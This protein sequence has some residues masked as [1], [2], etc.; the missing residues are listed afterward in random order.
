MRALSP[1]TCSGPSIF[2]GRPFLGTLL[3]VCPSWSGTP[4]GEGSFSSCAQM[5]LQHGD[6]VAQGG[7]CSG[8]IIE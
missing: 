2:H 5:Y 3:Q 7:E 4:Q 1:P 6:T 8:N